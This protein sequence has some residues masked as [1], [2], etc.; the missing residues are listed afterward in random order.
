MTRWPAP[1]AVIYNKMNI[2][3][4][5]AFARSFYLPSAG[6][7]IHGTPR[8]VPAVKRRARK[9]INLRYLTLIHGRDGAD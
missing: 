6:G 8:P 7:V 5:L 1:A 3:N 9:P 4:F 2:D